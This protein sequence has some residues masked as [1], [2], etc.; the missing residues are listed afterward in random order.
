MAHFNKHIYAI[1][2]L[3]RSLHHLLLDFRKGELLDPRNMA[4]DVQSGHPWLVPEERTEFGIRGWFITDRFLYP[5]NADEYPV[6]HI[7]TSLSDG[8]GMFVCIGGPREEEVPL[9]WSSA[10]R[11][12]R[13]AVDL[14]RLEADLRD[15]Y[16]LGVF[17][18]AGEKPVVLPLGCLREMAAAASRAGVPWLSHRI[19]T[20]KDCRNIMSGGFWYSPVKTSAYGQFPNKS[21]DALKKDLQ[22]AVA[23]FVGKTFDSSETCWGL[24]RFT[25]STLADRRKVLAEIE[26]SSMNV[27][28]EAVS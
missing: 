3:S 16:D 18:T 1:T 4:R 8:S 20:E 12:L 17:C 11:W 7:E 25:S 19:G 14:D 2:N 9:V 15:T 27:S 22:K 26:N 10:I 13:D 5:D 6:H 24:R 23:E 21:W 28:I